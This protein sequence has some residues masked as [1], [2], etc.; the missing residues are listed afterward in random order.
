MPISHP[1]PDPDGE[2]RRNRSQM[3]RDLAGRVARERDEAQTVSNREESD[4]SGLYVTNFTKGLPHDQHG[5]A[6]GA[7][8]EQLVDAICQPG[9]TD[10]EHLRPT[11]PTPPAKL[12][13]TEVDDK[14]QVDW[15][16]WESPRAGHVH[17]LEGPDAAEVAMP[18]APRLGGSELCAEMAELYAMAILRDVP[19]RRI[20]DESGGD[21][22]TQLDVESVLA[23][24]RK[25]SWFDPDG[26]PVS[27][28][29]DGSDRSLTLQERRRRTA[30]FHDHGSMDYG[31]ID[32]PATSYSR[33][34]GKLLFRG[35]VPG[36]KAGP[37]LSQF[38]LIGNRGRGGP[39]SPDGA[40]S[41][42]FSES[43]GY[44]VY[45]AQALDQRVFTFVPQL[46]YMTTWGG[47]LDVQRGADL[48]PYSV[49][50]GARRFLTTPRDLCAYVRLDQLYQA[51]L[52]ACL[53]MLSA[54]E[55]TS[56]FKF[57][58]GFP[59]SSGARAAFATFGGPHVLSLVTEVASR[60]LKAVRRQK[61]GFHRRARPE[62][63][64][65][66]LTLAAAARDGGPLHGQTALTRNVQEKCESMLDELD[67]SQ[68]LALVAHHNAL[69]RHS[70]NA[71]RSRVTPPANP[72]WLPEHRNY[73]LAMALPEGSP[74]HASYGAGHATV[75]GGCVTILKAFF[76]MY[77]DMGSPLM[78]PFPVYEPIDDGS[79][80]EKAHCAPLTLQGELNKLA[81]NI[82][83]GRNMAGVHYYTDYYES[84]RMGE[85]VA[86]GI[87]EEQMLTYG[88]PVT[89]RFD[90]FDGDRIVIRSP[91][92]A[93]RDRPLV[94]INGR[95]EAYSGWWTRHT[96][97]PPTAAGLQAA[98]E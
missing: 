67:R 96:I 31:P 53:L 65:G 2:A 42:S 41:V 86:V 57:D 28:F 79:R 82:A 72:E 7:R 68:I 32:D 85:R 19:F 81:A 51:Y 47:W 17:D 27:S 15:R 87:L 60:C 78:W 12:F 50:D 89:M 30:R 16:G 5:I 29:P 8:Y 1:I 25:L 92:A 66:L 46:D 43:D 94:T 64:A 88:E 21:E 39:R 18:P 70:P 76:E 93:G 61:F 26:R 3:V 80:L 77:D 6:D 9:P 52:N 40:T 54:R 84:L 37:L 14:P 69:R 90:S 11:Q 44:I 22:N 13:E 63:I 38:L 73:L 10:F 23:A 98:A 20:A 36:A 58:S 34:T 95:P 71:A 75:A 83:I 24:L 62:R 49:V 97:E 55:Y 45:G 74:M 48:R 33:L 35:S 91:Q 59:E 4:A 56:S